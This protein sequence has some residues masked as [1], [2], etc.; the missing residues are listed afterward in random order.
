MDMRF[1]LTL[2]LISAA[3]TQQPPRSDDQPRSQAPA[4]ESSS[5]QSIIDLSP[6]PNERRSI[7]DE[8]EVTGVNELKRFDPHK[9]AKNVEV[10]E[11][12]FKDKNYKAAISRFCEALEY[13]PRDAVATYRLATAFEKAGM[14]VDA[15]EYYSAYLKILKDGPFA[16]KAREGQQRLKDKTGEK[17]GCDA[18]PTR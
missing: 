4:G 18:F 15:R 11:Y 9:A 16:L 8:E 1:V 3:W 17:V 13:K 10:G 5:K 7:W 6:P 2:V 14:L 12:Y